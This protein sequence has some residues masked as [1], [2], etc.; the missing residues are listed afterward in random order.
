MPTCNTHIGRMNAIGIAKETTPGTAVDPTVWIPVESAEVMP[1][2]KTVEDTSGYGIID[3]IA[4]VQTVEN[5]SETT[6]SG[7]ARSESI[8]HIL[9]ATLGESVAPTTVE[10]GVYKH[11]FNRL[12]SNCPIT[13]TITEDTP[14]GAKQAPYSVI[15][16]IDIEAKVG[17]YVRYSVKYVGGQVVT[18]LDKT[19]SYSQEDIFLASGV[20]VKMADDV[21]GIAAASD[22]RAQSYKMTIEKSPEMLMA[23][24]STNVDSIH[25]TVFTVKGDMELKYDT[26]TYMNI[27]VSG[28]KKAIQFVAS[29]GALIGATK[30]AEIGAIVPRV[31]LSEWKKSSDADKIVT[32][33]VGFVGTFSVAEA[34]TLS[35][36]VQNKQSTQY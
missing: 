4:D 10:T 7:I 26:D 33:T 19:P 35:M 36:W 8:G 32:Q 22:I 9:L 5:T 12:N 25:N 27:V 17:D 15:D 18:V 3:Q 34:K 11:V 20:S 28:A 30:K 1:V 16:S 24:G 14:A 29:S 13:H 21:A 2:I 31:A 6:I 23:L